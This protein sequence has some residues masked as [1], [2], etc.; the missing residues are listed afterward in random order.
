MAFAA[1]GALFSGIAAG[2]AV[3]ATTALMAVSTIGAVMSVAG[4]VT[5]NKG[6]MKVGA[7]MGL[8]GGV[9]GLIAGA[10]AGAAGAV[11]GEVVGESAAGSAFNAAADSQLA[12]VAI[13]AAS[14]SGTALAGYT[15]D[16]GA[17][18]AASGGGVG[19]W[20]EA[21]IK[22]ADAMS[23][24]NDAASTSSSMET[25][26]GG[27]ADDTLT[28]TQ[29]SGAKAMDVQKV[30]EGGDPL[31]AAEQRI[32]PLNKNFANPDGTAVNNATAYTA[33]S[34]SSSSFSGSATP[35]KDYFNSILE[36]VNK[37]KE[38][39]KFGFDVLKGAFADDA[40]DDYYRAAARESVNRY[41]YGNTV[42]KPYASQ[43]LIGAR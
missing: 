42:A 23:A 16:A 24:L 30:I 22:A 29:S 14:G 37:N 15:V 41:Q 2:T 25:V 3:A 38:T 27:I 36:W 9:G 21:A 1:V 35:H 10:T 6:L 32:N 13:D 31:K 28:G 33:D 11:A 19:G 34:S 20:G 8:V 7:V 40:K 18:S 43:P 5:G 26:A 17:L 39:S 4:A 12:N